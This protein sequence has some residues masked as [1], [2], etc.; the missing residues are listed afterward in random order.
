MHKAGF[1]GDKGLHAPV[2]AATA[3]LSAAKTTEAAF[4]RRLHHG[5][6]SVFTTVLGPEANEAHHDHFH[7]D[8]KERKGSAICH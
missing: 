4:L 3:N 2:V 8:M 7:F 5:A 6:C 1:R